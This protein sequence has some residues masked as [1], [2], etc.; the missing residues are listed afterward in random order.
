MTIKW[1]RVNRKVHYWGAIICA[2]PLLIVL[3]RGLLLQVKK[4]SHWIQPVT[5]K[6]DSSVPRLSMETFLVQYRRCLV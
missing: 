1:Q 2:L 6:G 4:Q 5:M 3:I